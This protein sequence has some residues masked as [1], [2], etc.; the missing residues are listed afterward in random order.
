MPPQF[1]LPPYTVHPT[2]FAG[3]VDPWYQE[4]LGFAEEWPLTEGEGITLGVCDTGIDHDHATVGDL[5]HAFEEGRDF[6]GSGNYWDENEHGTHVSGLACARQLDG[7]KFCGGCRKARL[8]VAK[9]LD[10]NGSGQSDWIAD[11]IKWLADQGCDVI[12]GSFGAPQP[13][14][15]ILRALEE[16]QRGG[17]VAIIA[18]GNDGG[19]LNWPAR[20]EFCVSV[21]AYDKNRVAPQFSCRGEELDAAAPGVQ[22]VSCGLQGTYIV[23]S[24]TSMASPLLASQVVLYQAYR[25]KNGL[26]LLDLDGVLSWIKR[27]ATDV[28]APDH[29]PIFGDGILTGRS[30]LELE[31]TPPDTAPTTPGWQGETTP[32]FGGLLQVSRPAR[33]GDDYSVKIG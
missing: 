21:G 4:D 9:C 7:R 32:L 10:A 31:P 27:K 17:G 1:S 2:A 15:R 30:I 13:D 20:S 16:Y 26:A 18:A 29:D 5:S 8:K 3:A 23:L 25:K 14:D 12:N 28:G 19:K 11:G 24:G 22:I 6:T 33:P